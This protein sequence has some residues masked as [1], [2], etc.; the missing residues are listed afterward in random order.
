MST[1]NDIAM[2]DIEKGLSIKLTEDN[3]NIPAEKSLIE[4]DIEKPEKPVN[5]DDG[6][7][8]LDK[9]LPRC[10][11]R[12]T[13]EDKDNIP[14]KENLLEKGIEPGNDDDD[15]GSCL[16][17]CL[18]YFINRN[19]PVISTEDNDNISEKEKEPLNDDDEGSCLDK[20]LPNRINKHT[21]VILGG[22]YVFCGFLS[23]TF[24]AVLDVLL[25]GLAAIEHFNIC[26]NAA[27]LYYFCRKNEEADIFFGSCTLVLIF[28]P[29]MAAAIV[30]G[31][32]KEFAFHIPLV[33]LY[34]HVRL[35][36]LIKQYQMEWS[37]CEKALI[38]ARRQRK[39]L[40]REIAELQE[41]EKERQEK[42]ESQI[43]ELQEN[44]KKWKD[45]KEHS[46]KNLAKRQSELQQF[47]LFEAQGESY[48]QSILQFTAI[49]KKG[50]VNLKPSIITISCLSSSLLIL[51]LTM[52][53]LMV[54]LPL[55]IYN[56]E[57]V[58]FKSL[59]LQYIKIP[60]LI[61]LIIIPRMFTLCSF[62]SIFELSNSWLCIVILLVLVILYSIIYLILLHKLLKKRKVRIGPWYHP[63]K[64]VSE[65]EFKF[66]K[67]NFLT[68]LFIPVDIGNPN[69]S[70]YVFQNIFTALLYILLSIITILLTTFRVCTTT[71]VTSPNEHSWRNIYIYQIMCSVQIA[72]LLIGIGAA[73]L[74]CRI[75][76]NCNLPRMFLWACE[77][78]EDK[79]ASEFLESKKVDPSASDKD[80]K[81]CLMWACQQ[82]LDQ[83]VQ[84][85]LER[86][87]L[88]DINKRDE[89]GHTALM[90]A[91]EAK[92]FKFVDRL[93]KI[94]KIDVCYSKESGQTCLMWAIEQDLDQTAEKLLSVMNIIDINKKDKSETT[95][96]M[97]AIRKNKKNLTSI[98][99]SMEGIEVS[100]FEVTDMKTGLILA[101]QTN[102]GQL[103]K[104][105]LPNLNQENFKT[106]TDDHDH[107]IFMI[108]C[109]NNSDQ[110]VSILLDAQTEE[111]KLNLN[112]QDNE[113]NTGFMLACS[114]NSD[115][116]VSI[117]LEHHQNEAF[118]IDLPDKNGYNP[119]MN[120]CKNNCDKVVPI[121]LEKAEE[122]SIDLAKT[123]VKGNNG[124]MIACKHYSDKV[125]AI[126]LE[127][128][129][130][131]DVHKRNKSGMNG[132]M[133][134][135]EN[136]SSDK[137]LKMMFDK[138]STFQF[139][140]NAID[141][142]GRSGFILAAINKRE[143]AVD[144]ILA[145]YQ[146]HKIN[147]KYKNE[148]KGYS[149]LD[150]VRQ[151]WPKKTLPK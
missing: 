144:C 29:A 33:Q 72:A 34:Q 13:P 86:L 81:T 119:F 150:Y 17:K 122:H 1:A 12:N 78:G 95:A 36:I 22:L 132:F 98:F 105:L 140:F 147:I 112:E 90:Y 19:T 51:L 21:P 88:T 121:L 93:L 146:N 80:G 114:N 85:L 120:A 38:I 31:S 52:S 127:Q 53:G 18:A 102:F 30:K 145:N 141:C 92:Q 4:K 149:G 43:A 40:H 87:S 116:V 44:E 25:D 107:N 138:N 133:L 82:G 130:M 104:K 91:I 28:V 143:V 111:W 151:N 77:A 84:S 58:P 83:T 125:V 35:Q 39:G 49:L 15:G 5:D 137:V 55:R 10:I 63:L 61:A 57:Q 48:P 109:K 136:N 118:K 45:K 50:L 115:K 117:L 134:A 8:W 110:V 2:T 101:S 128:N 129:P 123:D 97:H 99:S 47:K 103:V 94:P 46:G 27:I 62:L 96:F 142:N 67:Q 60:L 3:D 26:A 108:A 71:Q 135:C 7:S 41:D 131:E 68:M 54:S 65:E 126:L 59:V 75:I 32:L 42:I 37:Y 124:F 73:Y 76:K 100:D 79:D 23:D 148:K 69:E 20:C 11:N 89:E 64:H 74:I 14:E 56:Q 70:F 139:D 106:F 66:F 24:L 6:G 9:C 113:G 16:D